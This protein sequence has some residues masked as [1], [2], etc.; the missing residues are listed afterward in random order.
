[1][2]PSLLSRIADTALELAEAMLAP[3][4]AAPAD[5]IDAE[6]WSW[7]QPAASTDAIDLRRVRPARRPQCGRISAAQAAG[8][9][10]TQRAPAA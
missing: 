2:F 4:P 1:M 9:A 6:R 5:A 8:G 10:G 7:P 3:Q